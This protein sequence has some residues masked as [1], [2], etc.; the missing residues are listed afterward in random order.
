VS[1]D[2]AYSWLRAEAAAIREDPR[3]CDVP[4]WGQTDI[5]G[6]EDAR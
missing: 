4:R 6:P 1:E 2:D 5:P 3:S